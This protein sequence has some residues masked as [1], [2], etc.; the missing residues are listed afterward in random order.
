MG[1]NG[2]QRLLAAAGLVVIVG[3]ALGALALAGVIGDS[4]GGTSDSGVPIE[5]VEFVETP[6]AAGQEDLED[7]TEEGQLAPDF[8]ISDIDGTR[9]T[10][11]DFRGEVVYVNFWATWCQPCVSELP[12]IQE[13]QNRN[14]DNLAVVTV[15][16]RQDVDDAEAFLENLPTLDG[17]NGVHFTVDG[18]DPEDEIYERYVRLKPAMPVS[19]FINADG[20]VTSVYNGLM[21]LP[22]MEQAVTEALASTNVAAAR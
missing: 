2:S 17:G 12:E 14:P 8:V 18:L 3:A 11:S 5:N 10:L 9:H 13:L 22:Q 16:R 4:D 21:Q 15:N 19:V 6:R 20:V 1:R 7:G